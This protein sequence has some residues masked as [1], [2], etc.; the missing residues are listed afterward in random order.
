VTIVSSAIRGGI[1][2]NSI[3]RT[4][5]STEQ[6]Y[7]DVIVSATSS[8]T[9]EAAK[10]VEPEA[11][12]EHPVQPITPPSK[13]TLVIKT[14]T[15]VAT[16]EA[17]SPLSPTKDDVPPTPAKDAAVVVPPPPAKHDDHPPAP[18]AKDSSSS[19][20]HGEQAA[21]AS[22]P[23][24]PTKE[25]PSVIHVPVASTP[26]LNLALL[27]KKSPPPSSVSPAPA[28]PAVPSP[29]SDQPLPPPKD[30]ETEEDLMAKVKG[31]IQARKHK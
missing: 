15:P 25:A 30:E 24:V 29:D 27:Q 2:L 9:L 31:A 16:H 17:P 12:E 11:P 23:A 6:T 7:E 8:P 4:L 3:M 14:S 21:P 13:D 28:P 5:S 1:S 22:A 20:G 19:S 10:E 18:V 26:V